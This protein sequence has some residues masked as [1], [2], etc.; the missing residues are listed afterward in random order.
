MNKLKRY[1]IIFLSCLT[2]ST[3]ATTVFT[4][5]TITA[6]AHSGRTDAY[7]GIM[8]TRI[9][10]VLGATITIATAIPRI[11]IQMEYARM[12][13]IFRQITFLRAEMTL[14]QRKRLRSP[15]I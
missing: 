5:N 1:G 11:C 15:M 12:Q 9:R 13:P 4:A 7:G 14:L 2:L 8:T 6:E 10:V 3:T